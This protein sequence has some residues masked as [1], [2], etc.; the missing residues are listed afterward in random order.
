M[1]KFYNRLDG[2]SLYHGIKR[3]GDFN[4][5]RVQQGYSKFYTI[6]AMDLI[7]EE[8]KFKFPVLHPHCSAFSREMSGTFV[9]VCDS[10]FQE[11]T[12]FVEMFEDD[13]FE[14]II[15]RKW[16]I[17]AKQQQNI[18]NVAKSI[19]YQTLPVFRIYCLSEM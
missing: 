17:G 8:G 18:E 10:L 19:E 13:T 11:K 3:D 5:E 1:S 2:A 15:G 4:P 6:L 9:I 16:K 12:E 7:D 14:Q